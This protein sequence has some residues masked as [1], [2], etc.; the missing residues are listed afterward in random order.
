MV[1][2]SHRQ[3]CCVGG[4]NVCHSFQHQDLG[5]WPGWPAWLCVTGL[6]SSNSFLLKQ[7]WDRCWWN[8]WNTSSIAAKFC[9]SSLGVSQH[10]TLVSPVHLPA[11]VHPMI[12]KGHGL[13]WINNENS[14]CRGSAMFIY[15]VLFNAPALSAD[16]CRPL[17]IFETQAFSLF[18][19]SSFCTWAEV[20]TACNH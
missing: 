17:I 4:I 7:M 20:S 10:N 18:S 2:I 16:Y 19:A 5:V 11:A 3:F 14:C 15:G 6:F 9:S 8:H 1:A 13:L 12:S